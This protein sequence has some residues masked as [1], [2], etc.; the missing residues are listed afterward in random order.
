ML[1]R[2]SVARAIWAGLR[3]LDFGVYD[4]LCKNDAVGRSALAPRCLTAVWMPGMPRGVTSS[5]RVAQLC[6][7]D[8]EFRWLVG[9]AQ[10]AKSTLCAFRKKH[11]EAMLSLSTQVL[12]V[13]GEHGLLPGENM[14]VD[15]TIVRA[16]SSRHSVKSR[17]HLQRQHE[18]LEEVLRDKLSQGDSDGGGSSD[19]FA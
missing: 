5:L 16:A 17:K 13:S 4:A 1:P 7:E 18:E 2:D 8:I 14:G 19:F 9:G 11:G 12:G 15:G 3:Q 6:D 10:V